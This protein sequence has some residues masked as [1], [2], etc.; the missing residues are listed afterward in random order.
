MICS[1]AWLINITQSISLKIILFYCELIFLSLFSFFNFLFKQSF[2]FL[3]LTFWRKSNLFCWLFYNVSK[4]NSWYTRAPSF[5]HLAEISYISEALA[6]C[7][8]L[9]VLLTVVTSILHRTQSA[10]L[11]WI[12]LFRNF[13]CK[14]VF[15]TWKYL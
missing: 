15:W 9:K 5:R 2:Y 13:D 14:F 7:K 8:F 3:Y 4:M 6:T 1:K 12:L 11:F 10:H